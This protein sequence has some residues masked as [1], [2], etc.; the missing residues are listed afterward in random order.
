MRVSL[1]SVRLVATL[2]AVWLVAGCGGT[3]EAPASARSGGPEAQVFVWES[4]QPIEAETV[5]RLKQALGARLRALGHDDPRIEYGEQRLTV[6][7]PSASPVVPPEILLRTEELGVHRV[8]GYADGSQEPGPQA[9]GRLVV[10]SELGP[11]LV[12]APAA[13]AAEDF[14]TAEVRPPGTAGEGWSVLLVLTPQGVESWSDLLAE[15]A[16]PLPDYPDRQLGIVLGDRLVSA[17]VI[18]PTAECGTGT[19]TTTNEIQ[20]SVGG[21]E[22]RAEELAVSVAEAALSGGLRLV[23][24]SD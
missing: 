9:D 5:E 19:D 14:S 2:V 23:S 24:P 6:A 17:P 10:S 1:A 13:L 4:D 16:C 7:L 11:L 18:D 12:L 3:P 22:Q 8:L 15:A 20:V 21:S